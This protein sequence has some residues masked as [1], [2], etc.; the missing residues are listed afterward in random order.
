V[1]ADPQRRWGGASVAAIG[2]CVLVLFV[3]VTLAAGCSS[4][5][6]S[7]TSDAP[8]ETNAGPGV[9]YVAVGAKE[10]NNRDRADL[11]DNWPQIVFAE[12]I[13]SGGIY[14][15]L[16]TDDA[17]VQSALDGQL[18]QAASLHP[19]IATV[20]VESSDARLGTPAS[21]YRQKL[22]ALVDGLHAAGATQILLLTPATSTTDA[23][24]DL[25]DSVAQVAKATGAT[26]VALGDVSDRADDAGQRRIADSVS[27]A[28]RGS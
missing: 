19:T 1:V 11:Q 12:S 5:G 7:T 18:P 21:V 23:G 13:P 22:T 9:V 25:A 10:T 8:P 14:V 16:A 2:R 3:G 15:N 4:S 28:L 20:W 26:L 17:T 24:G 6:G 27:G